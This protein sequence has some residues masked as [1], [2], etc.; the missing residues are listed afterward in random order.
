MKTVAHFIL[1]AGAV[2][3]VSLSM[4]CTNMGWVSGSPGGSGSE[5]GNVVVGKLYG[6]D[7]NLPACSASVV[8]RSR[9]YLPEIP[10]LGK[11]TAGN[12]FFVCSK[13]TDSLG[14]Y[15]FTTNDSIPDDMYCIEGRDRNNNC[16][17]IDSIRIDSSILNDTIAPHILKP[18]GTIRDSIPW[19][20]DSSK[21]YIRIFGLDI[22]VGPDSSGIVMLENLPKGNLRLHFSIIQGSEKSYDATVITQ[23]DSMIIIRVSDSLQQTTVTR[24]L[25][26]ISNGYG[27]VDVTESPNTGSVYSIKA[28]AA[29]GYRFAL[30]RVAKGSAIIADPSSAS[31]TVELAENRVT[32]EGVFALNSFRKEY[33]FDSLQGYMTTQSFSVRQTSD[34]G[35]VLAGTI[36]NYS[37]NA[38]QASGAPGRTFIFLVKTDAKGEL[39]WKRLFNTA[40]G[41]NNGYCVRQTIDGGFIIVGESNAGGSGG[42]DIVAIKTHPNGEPAWTHYFGGTGYD[43]GYSVQQTTDGGYII[44][45]KTDSLNGMGAIVIVKTDPNGALTWSRTYNNKGKG[46]SIFQT[47]DGGYVFTGAGDDS[48]QGARLI[49]ISAAGDILWTRTYSS[50]DVFSEGRSVRQAAD[51][52]YVLA[53]STVGMKTYI[54]KTDSAGSLTWKNIIGEGGDDQYDCKSGSQTHDDGFVVSGQKY[55]SVNSPLGHNYELFL[56]KTDAT[57][58]TAWI[59]VIGDGSGYLHTGNF[60]NSVQ[61]TDDGGFV[62]A[63]HFENAYG[64]LPVVLIKTDVNGYVK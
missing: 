54:L 38:S 5:V 59:R 24:S 57:G 33:V 30:W 18:S 52:G 1:F 31:T 16:I 23:A 19:H 17:F 61:E 36:Y 3:I 12:G 64:V 51:G 22:C 4:R 26:L 28:V 45:G 13:F 40:G 62:L 53:G 20:S 27:T 7:G 10:S 8:M 37:D 34:K 6:P 9:N 15:Q 58:T 44:S 25:V 35:Y 14:Y 32:L 11:R 48:A 41:F 46:N 29:D 39:Q 2:L 21:T 47:D 50:A 56:A 49:K 60:G 42:F 55:S 63:G 43:H